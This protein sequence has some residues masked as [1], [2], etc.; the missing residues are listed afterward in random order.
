M[1]FADIDEPLILAD[2]TKIDPSNGKVLKD[3]KSR[4]GMIAIP[5]ASEAQ[6][7]V[8]RTRRS[9]A[10]LPLPTGQMSVIGLTLF[11]TMWGLSNQDIAVAINLTV[12]QIANIKKLPEYTT[13][14]D[15]VKN[16]VLEHETADIRTFFQQNA[17]IA[18]ENIL[19]AADEGG[20]LG[21][22]ASQD[23][24]D[25]AGHRPADIVEHKHTMQNSLTIEY[26][27]KTEVKDIPLINVTPG[28]DF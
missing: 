17:R 22:K 9:V 3:R 8:A 24:L 11:Y 5:S 2:G 16:A 13:A 25:R 6:A 14:Q 27:R 12:E 26:V 7:I 19:E 18:A 15:D 23:I 21:F 10:E 20:V 1:S 28:E 4:S